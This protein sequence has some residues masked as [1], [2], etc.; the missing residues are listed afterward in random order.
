MK[1]IRKSFPVLFLFLLLSGC[2]RDDLCPGSTPVTPLLLIEFYDREEPTR[3]KAVPN[4]V[5][6][7]TGE[8]EPLLGPI[9]TNNI[10]IPLR[11]DQNHTE[12]RFVRDA[13]RETENIDTITFTYST[14]EQYL[15]RA[16]GY[17]VNYLGI[18]ASVHQDGDTWIRSQIIQQTDVVNETEVHIYLIH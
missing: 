11:T 6:Q 2:Q 15:N 14:S 5:V 9:T 17:I 8:D 7:A 4:L 1:I 10:L 16:C 13:N 12:Y 3:L 18:D